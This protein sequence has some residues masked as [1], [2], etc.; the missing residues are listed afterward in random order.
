MESPFWSDMDCYRFDLA[1]AARSSFAVKASPHMPHLQV[2]F[3]SAG[4]G[5]REA[6]DGGLARNTA[7]S[8]PPHPRQIFLFMGFLTC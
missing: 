8:S 1:F 5:G 4:T 7:T 6:A 3:G 2:E